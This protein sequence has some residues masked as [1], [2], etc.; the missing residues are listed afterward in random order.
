[1]VVE[2]AIILNS[3]SRVACSF[4]GLGGWAERNKGSCHISASYKEGSQNT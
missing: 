4:A 3:D 1:M 2:G